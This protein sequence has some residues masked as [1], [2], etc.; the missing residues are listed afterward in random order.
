MPRDPDPIFEDRF[1]A[2]GLPSTE[3]LLDELDTLDPSIS[4]KTRLA[5]LGVIL[6]DLP[7]LSL[8]WQAGSLVS[9]FGFAPT[10]PLLRA[11]LICS[12]LGFLSWKSKSPLRELLE[13][14]ASLRRRID[15]RLA[16]PP[17]DDV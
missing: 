4:K 17:D 14:K 6:F 12:A 8:V 15:A 1:V 3:A 5:I 10:S 9:Q 7:I 13:E 11:G 2:M 16:T